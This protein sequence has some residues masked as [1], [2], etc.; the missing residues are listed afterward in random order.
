MI[1]AG[2]KIC[3]VS[4]DLFIMKSISYHQMILILIGTKPIFHIVVISILLG[5]LI[6]A[7]RSFPAI[8]KQTLGLSEL[9][10]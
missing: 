6:L 4:K 9:I 2:V 3:S 5:H 7:F 8:I 10:K 1:A